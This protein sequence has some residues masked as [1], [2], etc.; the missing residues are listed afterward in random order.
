MA[1]VFIE[2]IRG[3]LRYGKGKLKEWIVVSKL[4]WGWLVL[5]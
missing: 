3:T 5:G 1:N 4:V 2:L